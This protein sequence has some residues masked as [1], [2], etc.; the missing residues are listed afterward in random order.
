MNWDKLNKQNLMTK[1]GT[2]NIKPFGIPSRG[3]RTGKP[4]KQ[5]F[6]VRLRRLVSIACT[7]EKRLLKFPIQPKPQNDNSKEQI[8]IS[9][10]ELTMAFDLR[11][12]GVKTALIQK[13]FPHIK[14]IGNKMNN[15]KD[16]P[17]YISGKASKKCK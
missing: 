16:H 14:Y 1:Y 5:S 2:D 7:R 11:R 13:E 10:Q 8:G 6:K 12:R 4:A 17:N 9:F 3:I 15:A